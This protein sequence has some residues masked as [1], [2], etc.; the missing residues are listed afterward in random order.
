[1]KQAIAG[2]TLLMVTFCGLA[3]DEPLTDRRTIS[4]S[5]TAVTQA[6]PDLILWHVDIQDFDKDLLAAKRTNDH[7]VRAIIGLREDLGLLEADIE[8]GQVRIRREYERDEQGHQGAFKHF[9]ISR[10]V[11][12]RQRDLDRFDEF[13]QKLVESAAPEFFLEFQSTRI[14]ELRAEMRLKALRIA[15]EKAEALAGVVGARL[16]EALKID[17]H[18]PTSVQGGLGGGGGGF[19]MSAYD[20][21]ERLEPDIGISTFM[22]GPLDIRVTVFA[23]FELY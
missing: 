23:T 15:R 21:G 22:P 17:E 2:W 6:K 19:A 1:M 14:Q 3:A 11:L 16:G 9:S 10:S 8:T 20:I 7:R 13:L 18:L 5:G 12:L 4:V